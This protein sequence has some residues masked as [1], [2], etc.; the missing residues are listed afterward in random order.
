MT[1]QGL[2]RLA[3]KES[4]TAR[5]RLALYMS[6]IALGVTALVA[7]DSFAD[8]VTRSIR[9]QSRTLLGGD[10]ALETRA[11]FSPAVDSLLDSLAA[12]GIKNSRLTSLASMAMAVPVAA[13]DWGSCVQLRPVSILRVIETVPARLSRGCKTNPSHWSTFAACFH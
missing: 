11:A 3:W 5:K 7:I 13:T 10:L 9:E 6:S 1:L 8:N 4:R 2:L 12:S